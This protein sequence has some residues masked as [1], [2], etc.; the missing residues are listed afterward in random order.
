MKNA[1]LPIRSLSI[2]VHGALS[3][4]QTAIEFLKISKSSFLN[5]STAQWLIGVSDQKLFIFNFHGTELNVVPTFGT[6]GLESPHGNRKKCNYHY[7]T[8]AAD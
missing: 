6:L 3:T 8:H 4:L 2:S 1:V 7:R 5:I